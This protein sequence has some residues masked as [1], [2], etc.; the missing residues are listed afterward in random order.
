MAVLRVCDTHR[1]DVY[2]SFADILDGAV[3]TN[4]G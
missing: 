1:T 3:F 4:P 2:G